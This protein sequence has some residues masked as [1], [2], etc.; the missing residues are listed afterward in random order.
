MVVSVAQGV[1]PEFNPQ[2]CRNKN[3]KLFQY[4][5]PIIEKKKCP[6]MKRQE[7]TIQSVYNPSPYNI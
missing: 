7:V 4:I 2:Y 6:L 3:K 5:M 1:G